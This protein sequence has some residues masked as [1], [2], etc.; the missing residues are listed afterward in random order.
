MQPWVNMHSRL[1]DMSSASFTL[2][3][4]VADNSM[5]VCYSHN[6]S[7]Y[8]NLKIFSQVPHSTCSDVPLVLR[9]SMCP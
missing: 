4:T 3:D 6:F 1:R 7:R 9:N 8:C 2:K 5:L